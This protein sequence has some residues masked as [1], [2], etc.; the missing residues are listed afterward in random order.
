MTVAGVGGLHPGELCGL[1]SHC[2]P[3]MQV[4]EDEPE[5]ATTAKTTF[6]ILVHDAALP[7]MIK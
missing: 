1:T 4:L 5:C 2:Y 7:E 6:E 3:D